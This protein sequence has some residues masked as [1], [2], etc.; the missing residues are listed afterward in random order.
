MN[1]SRRTG[2]QL[3]LA[4]LKCFANFPASCSVSTWC[5][6]VLRFC[7]SQHLRLASIIPLLQSPNSIALVK[8]VESKSGLTRPEWLGTIHKPPYTVKPLFKERKAKPVRRCIDIQNI[9][10]GLGDSMLWPFRG[11]RALSALHSYEPF[12]CAIP[13]KSNANSMLLTSDCRQSVLYFGKVTLP[14]GVYRVFFRSA[15]RSLRAKC[16]RRKEWTPSRIRSDEITAIRPNKQ[17]KNKL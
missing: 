1:G 5:V 14:C 11:V 13:N 17:T 15:E 8:V 3:I 7:T 6:S 10:H 2:I 12:I 4:T 9:P 16:T